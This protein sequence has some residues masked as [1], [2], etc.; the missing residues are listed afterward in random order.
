MLFVSVVKALWSH[1]NKK[2]RICR[3]MNWVLRNLVYIR[4]TWMV[5]FPI[6]TTMQFWEL[7]SLEGELN[8]SY[9]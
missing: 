9:I 2:R 5:F 7:R 1:S 4:A 6:G 3:E 8:F